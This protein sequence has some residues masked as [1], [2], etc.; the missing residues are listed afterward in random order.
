V[1][2][3][4]VTTVAERPL[5][6]LVFAGYVDRDRAGLRFFADVTAVYLDFDG[7][8]ARFRADDDN[9]W[10]HVAEVDRISGDIP[11]DDEDE[12][13]VSSLFTLLLGDVYNRR[14][15]DELEAVAAPNVPDALLRCDLR[16]EGGDRLSIEPAT[17]YGLRVLNGR[18]PVDPEREI[19]APP[20]SIRWRRGLGAAGRI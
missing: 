6:D 8:L 14:R 16:F 5:T 9:Y 1:K 3:D 12:L 11:K 7:L 18:R 10:V 20:P 19:A 17:P 13:C 4:L 15:V 2:L